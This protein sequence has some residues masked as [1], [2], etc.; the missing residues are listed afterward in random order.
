MTHPKDQ[1]EPMRKKMITVRLGLIVALAAALVFTALYVAVAA[2]LNSD[3]PPG[4]RVAGVLAPDGEHDW[5]VLVHAGQNVDITLRTKPGYSGEA[6]LAAFDTLATD[7]VPPFSDVGIVTGAGTSHLNFDVPYDTM[8]AL[9]VLAP[10]PAFG[11]YT[12]DYAISD[13]PPT[14]TISRIAGPS[15]YGTAISISQSGWTTGSAGAVV[16]ASGRDF[17]DGLAASGLAGSYGCPVL[18]TEPAVLSAGVDDEVT[19]LGA[20]QVFVIGGPAAVSDAVLAALDHGGRTITRVAG[21]TRY[22]T[23]AAVAAQMRAHETSEGRVPS[24]EAL[25]VNG[26]SYPDA[27]AASPIAYARKMPILLVSSAGVPSATSGELASMGATMSYVIGGAGAVPDSVVASLSTDSTRVAGATRQQTAIAVADFAVA[28]GWSTWGTVG[29]STGWAYPDALAAGA[30]LGKQGG[31]MLLTRPTYLVKEAYNKLRDNR[32][33]ITQVR[34]CGGTGAVFG[35]VY[36]SAE[37]A[38]KGTAWVDPYG[39]TYRYVPW[40]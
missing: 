7:T 26:L 24:T 40:E 25:I 18:L 27:L 39:F 34:I 6:W 1:E 37:H 8:M 13:P 15:R 17:P 10:A 11:G 23:A 9:S 5:K 2:T 33:T 20:T 32:A 12:L 19:R 35:C 29:L 22:A 3:L 38:L 21:P 16:I 36:G 4:A 14:S 31:V 28:R 30:L